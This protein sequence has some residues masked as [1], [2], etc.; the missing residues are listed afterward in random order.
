MGRWK[1]RRQARRKRTWEDGW[2]FASEDVEGD[3]FPHTKDAFADRM[4][5]SPFPPPLIT[6]ACSERKTD[7]NNCV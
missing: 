5:A 4:W 1:D 6:Q 7:T 3:G 2:P